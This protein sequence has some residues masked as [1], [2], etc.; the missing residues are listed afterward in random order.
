MIMK[1]NPHGR[2]GFL[3]SGGMTPCEAEGAARYKWAALRIPTTVEVVADYGCGDGSG[4]RFIHQMRPKLCLVGMDSDPDLQP[5]GFDYFPGDV[6]TMFMSCDVAIAFEIYEHLWFPQRMLENIHSGLCDGGRLLLS[7]PNRHTY[8]MAG[9][10]RSH[11]REYE[12]NEAY[13]ALKLAGFNTVRVFG[14]RPPRTSARDWITK[15]KRRFGINRSLFHI[16]TMRPE[17]VQITEN[18][19]SAPIIIF[20]AFK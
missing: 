10:T 2:T 11:L 18:D 5:Q 7:T 16:A 15:T 3:L 14:E 6:E 9:H 4:L 20:E 19:S 8:S 13:Q 1:F 17:D 12:P